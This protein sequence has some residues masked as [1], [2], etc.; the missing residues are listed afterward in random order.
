YV[1][2]IMFSTGS[3]ATLHGHYG[4]FVNNPEDDSVVEGDSSFVLEW[5]IVANSNGTT[6]EYPET[7]LG[8]YP[9]FWY[10]D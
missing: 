4:L 2:P 3:I 6:T 10:M 7:L 8:P 5:K 1:M 9:G